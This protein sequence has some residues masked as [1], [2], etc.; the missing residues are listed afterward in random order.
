[1]A[2][3]SSQPPIRRPELR[4][5]VAGGYRRLCRGERGVLEADEH[6]PDVNFA[7]YNKTSNTPISTGSINSLAGAGV[8]A[9]APYGLQVRVWKNTGTAVLDANAFGK[10]Y[11]SP[12][13]LRS[14]EAD[15]GTAN[16]Q[17]VSWRLTPALQWSGPPPRCGL[18]S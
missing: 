16:K 1:M 4:G 6:D 7:I 9:P 8:A 14:F 5:V 12:L 11:V 15:A 17:N 2:K 10:L 3:R 13:E 18:S